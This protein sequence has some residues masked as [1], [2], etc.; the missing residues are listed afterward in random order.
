MRSIGTIT[1]LFLP[2]VL[3]AVEPALS[4]DEAIAAIKKHDG[5]IV[6]DA[7]ISGDPVVEVHFGCH[8]DITDDVLAQ[9]RVF[10]NLHTVDLIS[11]KITDDGLKNFQHMP[12]LCSLRLNSSSIKD[13]GMENLKALKDLQV[14][15]LMRCQYTEAGMQHL[16]S[17]SSLKELWLW[18]MP[19]N[20]KTIAK[21]KEFKYL[22]KLYLGQMHWDNDLQPADLK[23]ALPQLEIHDN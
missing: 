18:R 5:R 4:R 14:L 15:F 3:F 10:P 19:V 21:L 22:G 12:K 7:K 17:L 11:D 1:L 16:K 6:E 9:L 13:K 23:K 2:G 8:S 20:D